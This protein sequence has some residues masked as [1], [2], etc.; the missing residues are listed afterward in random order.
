MGQPFGH[1][2]RAC[3]L[4][5]RLGT[6]ARLS[7]EQLHATYYVA[8]LRWIGCTADAHELSTIFGDEIAARTHAATVDVGDRLAVARAIIALVPGSLPAKVVTLVRASRNLEVGPAVHCAVATRLA[9]RLGCDA[10]VQRAL[11]DVFERW[12]GRG[13]PRGLHRDEIEIAARVA[14]LARDLDTFHSLGGSKAV[15]E[16]T[17]ARGGHAY[18]PD[19]AL[20]AGAEVRTLFANLDAVS[21][22]EAIIAAEPAPQ[23][24]I[25]PEGLDDALAVIADFTDLKSPSFAGHSRGVAALA[26]AA[27]LRRGIPADDA[28]GVCRAGLVHDI[29]R[30]AVTDR[31]WERPGPLTEGEREMVRLHAYHGE[32]LLA[33]GALA[34]IGA[35]AAGHHERLD[36]SGYH[37]G[38]RAGALSAAARV[39]AAADAFHA[40][41]EVRPHRPALSSAESAR[42][43]RDEARLGR[44]EPESVEAVL[45][46]SGQAAPRERATAS[47]TDREVEVL[48]LVARGL[49]NKEIGT[50]LAIA[51]ATV[52]HHVLHIYEKAG[53]S[54][55]A[56]AT[57]YA[58]ERGL[59][60]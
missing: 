53:V 2:L 39:L 28:V 37:R 35:L 36:G 41:L 42:F 32:R 6:L 25:G 47:L 10:S 3:A 51:P 46:A 58:M 24:M 18:D 56:T 7:R 29:G 17:Q 55:R 5:M 9:E 27:A 52:H 12:D 48:R 23:T 22:R 15:L 34:P 57:L 59:L 33:H 26:H 60:E 49:T 14:V 44:L 8:L 16:V 43:L 30:V 13:G 4:A 31:I 11:G 38:A 50:R 40:M 21:G 1:G 54:G 19:L 45:S 20:L